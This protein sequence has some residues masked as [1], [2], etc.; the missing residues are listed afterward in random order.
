MVWT[1]GLMSGRKLTANE[2][3]T[4]R[5][6]ERECESESESEERW[7]QTEWDRNRKVGESY[8]QREAEGDRYKEG[9]EYTPPM[10]SGNGSPTRP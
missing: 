9:P 1:L 6:R 4:K 8:E 10:T 3:G 7:T 2:W 5:E